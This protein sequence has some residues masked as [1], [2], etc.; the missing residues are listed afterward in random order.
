MRR[1]GA[2]VCLTLYAAVLAP[3]SARA[4][5]KTTGHGDQ[6]VMVREQ[7]PEDQRARFD[8][9]KVRCT[10]C[11]VMA[12][13]IMALQTG[14]APVTGGTFDEETVKKY[15]VKMMRKPNSG[16]AKDDAKEILLFLT[17]ALTLTEESRKAN[18]A[19]RSEAVP[20]AS[21]DTP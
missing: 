15:V 9:F 21:P 7:F 6:T 8:V 10:K 14:V 16:I 12:R 1:C 19:Q 18:A 17:Y 3:A 13:P 20:P 4:E 5:L 2:L 11:H